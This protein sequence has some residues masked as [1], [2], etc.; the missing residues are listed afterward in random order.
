MVGE[1]ARIAN[2]GVDISRKPAWIE[3]AQF[4]CEDGY[5]PLTAAEARLAQMKCRS[6]A[7]QKPG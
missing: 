5:C 6:A 1:S 2:G 4:V 7:L 3:R